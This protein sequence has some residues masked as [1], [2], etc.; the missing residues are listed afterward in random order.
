MLVH[1]HIRNLAL[2]DELDIEIQ[3]GLTVLT[4]ETGA[5]KSSLI[6]AIGM[7]L[8]QRAD[9]ALVRAGAERAEIALE[10][11]IA[12]LPDVQAWLSAQDRDDQGACQLR[13][14]I[15]REGRSR[16]YINGSP[17]PL[18]QLTELGDLR[19]DIHGQHE[20]HTLMTKDYQRLLLDRYG[21]HNAQTEAVAEH[22][23]AWRAIERRT[24]GSEAT[25]QTLTV[26]QAE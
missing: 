19:L 24:Q 8:G 7:A 26:E 16:A 4:G 15:N 21:N 1:L 3:P 10:F 25:A 12:N 9:A 18:Q 5:G 23:R 14:V 17:A 13:R 22:W 20:Q 2:C 11:D 6:G